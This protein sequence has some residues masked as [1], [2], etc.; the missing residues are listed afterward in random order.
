MF[1]IDEHVM[2]T[3]SFDEFVQ[4]AEANGVTKE[5]Q[6][7]A[8]LYLDISRRYKEIALLKFNANN[9]KYRHGT[10]HFDEETNQI[11]IK[12]SIVAKLSRAISD[13]FKKHVK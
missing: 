11:I 5:D 6:E 12:E 2:K 7:K 4:I 8:T 10:K 3:V 1:G 9:K 13:V